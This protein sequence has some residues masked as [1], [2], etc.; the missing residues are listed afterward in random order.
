MSD[1][2]INS[3]PEATETNAEPQLSTP[4]NAT[5]A[6]QPSHVIFK[7]GANRIVADEATAKLSPEQARTFLKATYPEVVNATV[8]ERIEGDTKIVEFL[9][10]PG[11]KG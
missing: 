1:Q 2:T 6:A 8:R 10:Q 3:Q 7:I 11:R 4:D 5:T 9:P